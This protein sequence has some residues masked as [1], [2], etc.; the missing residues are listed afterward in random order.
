LVEKAEKR[1]LTAW[2]RDG[3]GIVVGRWW[4]IEGKRSDEEYT[5]RTPDRFTVEQGH[6]VEGPGSVNEPLRTVMRVLPFL[7]KALLP[8]KKL[9]FKGPLSFL[10]FTVAAEFLTRVLEK[11]SDGKEETA[12]G[13]SDA[14]DTD[15]L[16]RLAPYAPHMLVASLLL[17]V[18]SCCILGVVLAKASAKS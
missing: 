9:L 8:L 7:G 18:A 11:L 1:A 16:C 3:E 4:E 15:M 17:F 10:A 13:Q 6:S 5:S 2:E 14:C 12:S